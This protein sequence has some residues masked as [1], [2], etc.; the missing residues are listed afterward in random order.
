MTKDIECE[1]ENCENNIDGLC[2]KEYLVMS[3]YSEN[4]PYSVYCSS[5]NEKS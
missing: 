5:F 3:K 4:S 2:S 1:Q